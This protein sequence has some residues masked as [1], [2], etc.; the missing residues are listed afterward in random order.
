VASSRDNR[1]DATSI[2]L[3]RRVTYTALASA[4]GLIATLVTIA[5]FTISTLVLP[6]RS[7]SISS[8]IERVEDNQKTL[9][10][11]LDAVRSEVASTTAR[12]ELIE[13]AIGGTVSATIGVTAT[14]IP[15]TT[16]TELAHRL[17]LADQRQELDG[18]RFDQTDLRADLDHVLFALGDDPAK[19]LGLPLLRKDL[20]NLSERYS[21]DVPN[22]QDQINLVA[23]SSRWYLA[24]LVTLIFSV[25]GMAFGNL[26]DAARRRRDDEERP[27]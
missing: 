9:L 23:D 15:T 13:S 1:T 12:V 16:K 8:R 6:Q 21:F 7:D 25:A 17:E 10:A 14:D 20:D 26:R 27:E 24:F 2:R 18:L 3:V 4:L 19:V 22:L 11:M 5:A